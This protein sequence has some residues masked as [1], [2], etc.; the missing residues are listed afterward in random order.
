MQ[1]QAHFKNAMNLN[2]SDSERVHHLEF[3]RAIGIAKSM[4]DTIEEQIKSEM[5]GE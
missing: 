4:L 5:K 1:Y 2:L 3:M